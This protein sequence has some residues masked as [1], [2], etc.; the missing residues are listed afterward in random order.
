M[1]VVIAP[2]LDPVIAALAARTGKAP[3]PNSTFATAA[4][5][6]I[7][8]LSGSPR[9]IWS[10]AADGTQGWRKPVISGPVAYEAPVVPLPAPPGGLVVISVGS[11]LNLSAGVTSLQSQ[12]E[13]LRVKLNEEIAAKNALLIALQGNGLMASS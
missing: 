8:W 1:A 9:D 12:V 2:I 4:D 6:S 5:G 13:S 11:L 10:V 3:V 7:A